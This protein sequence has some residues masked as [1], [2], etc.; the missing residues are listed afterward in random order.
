MYITVD[1]CAEIV[2]LHDDDPSAC[3]DDDT[4]LTQC[5]ERFVKLDKHALAMRGVEGVVSAREMI[6]IS[7]LHSHR[8]CKSRRGDTRL[9]GRDEL[10][11]VVDGVNVPLR[12]DRCREE[13]QE[14]AGTAA[15]FEHAL[16]RRQAEQRQRSLCDRS[17][18]GSLG[19]LL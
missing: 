7:V 13:R 1:V 19:H 4:H 8:C 3:L 12:P 11:R 9:R 18:Q 2:W 17:C 14:D 6:S 16:T 5:G 10:R 15:D